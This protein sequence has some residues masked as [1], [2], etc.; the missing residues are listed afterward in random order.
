MEPLTLKP[1]EP[2]KDDI[3]C[4]DDDDD[5]QGIDDLH[6]RHASTT[7]IGSANASYHRES[8]S[9]RISTRSDQESFVGGDE[10]WQVLLPDD[11][12]STTDAIASAKSAGIPIP[13]DVPASALLGGTIKRLGGRRLKKVLGD[14]WGEDLELSKIEKGGLKLKKPETKDFSDALRQFSAEFPSSPSPAKL[15]SG[16]TFMQRMESARKVKPGNQALDKFKDGDDDDFFGDVSTIKV[17]KIRSLQKPLDVATPATK[18]SKDA[19]DLENDIEFPPDGEPLR[20]STRKEQPKTPAS[21]QPDDLDLEWAEGSLGTRF[22]GTRREA[23]SNPSSTFS[24]SASSCLTAES[25]DEGLDGLVLP[26]GPLKFDEV[27]KKRLQSVSPDHAGSS[28]K[29]PMKQPTVLKDDFFTGIDIGDGE[30]FDS[31]K[32][33]LNRNVKLHAKRQTSPKRTATTLTFTNKSQ[34]GITRIPKPQGL[35][36]SGNDRP[37]TTLESVSE[38]GG[39]VPGY[40]QPQSRMGGHS[41]HSSLSAIPT[42][43]TP[44]SHVAAPS[45]PS[46]RGLITKSSRD[47][48]RGETT[49]PTQY[50]KAKRS[51]PIMPSQSPARSQPGYQ[52]PPSRSEF[53]HRQGLV[54][55]PKTPID[56]LGAESSLASARKPPVPFLPAGM[57]HAQSHHINVKSS[58]HLSRPT[59]SDGNENAPLNRP[60]SRLSNVQ[61]RPTTPT[62]RRD[63]AP[64]S[65]AREAASK[66]TLTKPTRRRAF[67]DGNELEVFDDL[68]TSASTESK[69]TKQPIARGAPK[70]VQL[71]SKLG[72]SHLNNSSSTIESSSAIP[73]STP[74]SPVKQDFTPRFAR[75]TNA[76]RLAREQRIGSV[77]AALHAAPL[78]P[79]VRESGPLNPISTNWKSRIDAGTK[80]LVSPSV[81]RVK[82]G[83]ALPQ[84]PKLIKPIGDGHNHIKTLKGMQWN[85]TLFRWEGNENALAPFDVPVT[86][87]SPTLAS[88][89]K[90]KAAPALIANV[91]AT[92]GVQVVGGMVFDPQRM[93][94]LKMAP[95][96]PSYHQRSGSSNPMSPDPIEEDEDPFAGLD[97]LVDSKDKM[98]MGGA[99]NKEVELGCKPMVDDEWLVGEEFDVGPAFVQRQ[100][101]EEE[102]WRRKVE[103]WVGEGRKEEED[104]RW[105][106]RREVEV[107]QAGVGGM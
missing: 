81:Q 48:L 51:Q 52:R 2:V 104:W 14:D 16:M 57:S 15:A 3:D 89:G 70:S 76:S 65:L 93:C 34:P 47:N 71:R 69:F 1:R 28:P 83:K 26:E 73:P 36:R 32:L 45:T 20:L 19:E 62:G 8:I 80:G 37:R 12:S 64:E 95:A 18:P 50:L 77:G 78:L 23:R 61:H 105:G 67:G 66:R 29:E 100:R 55:R 88:G 40:R 31:K 86:P 102:K 101:T 27:L 56:R 21:Q 87:Q 98:S 39:P 5:L 85:P 53:G 79:T 90:A 42:P 11:D 46:R 6:F 91:G 75:D 22:G 7:T 96:N 58:R 59:S 43:S 35:D 84:K 82:R 74:L 38:A 68:P 94:W 24:P 13:S 33:T 106:I 63:V 54:S 97:D 107:L 30:V 99:G 25:E 17:A 103:G 9:S 60:M 92:K 41:A 44:S 4:W 10:D 49:N 72:L